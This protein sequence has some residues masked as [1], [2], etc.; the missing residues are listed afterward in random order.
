MVY[1]ENHWTSKVNLKAFFDDYAAKEDFNP[2]VP[3]NWYQTTTQRV[4]RKV[5]TFLL[6]LFPMLF[7]RFL[8]SSI[9][10]RSLHV[11]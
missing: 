6:T 10:P 3:G 5:S 8:L 1:S 11:Y 7:N 4:L 9:L 2:L